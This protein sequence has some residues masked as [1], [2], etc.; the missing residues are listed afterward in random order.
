M[1]KNSQSSDENVQQRV[2]EGPTVYATRFQSKEGIK[3]D[4]LH[5]FFDSRDWRKGVILVNGFNVG[6]YWPERG[7]QVT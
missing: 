4:E 7:P 6:R 2:A 3:W 1:N 5:T